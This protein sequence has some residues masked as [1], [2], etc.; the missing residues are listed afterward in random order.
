MAEFPGQAVQE[1][2]AVVTNS[3]AMTQ[4]WCWPQ[5]EI[6]KAGPS[7]GPGLWYTVTVET[8]TDETETRLGRREEMH[9]AQTPCLIMMGELLSDACP[10]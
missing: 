5:T 10:L 4:L 9:V 3:K 8:F 6:D 7:K 1:K 2:P